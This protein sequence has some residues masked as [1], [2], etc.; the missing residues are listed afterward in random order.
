MNGEL[1]RI[2]TEEADGAAE[3]SV[4]GHFGGYAGARLLGEHRRLESHL[5]NDLAEADGS[6]GGEHELAGA[7]DQSGG[8]E[9]V[10]GVKGRYAVAAFADDLVY[11]SGSLAVGVDE[12]V[13]D[14][15]LGVGLLVNR[16]KHRLRVR[17]GSL[18]LLCLRPRAVATAPGPLGFMESPRLGLCAVMG[19]GV[20]YG[21]AALAVTGGGSGVR[22]FLM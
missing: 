5:P 8:V 17:H 6:A 14:G 13:Q 10:D 2:D 9:T 20:A 16:L 3:G 15:P 1:S 19:Q 21:L 22:Y 11:R 12:D 7:V 18:F 4:G